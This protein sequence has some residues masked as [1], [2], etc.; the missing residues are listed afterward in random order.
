M[1]TG[2]GTFEMLDAINAKKL[3]GEKKV[4]PEQLF[5]VGEIVII[6]DSR[7]RIRSIKPDGDMRLK[8]LP[9]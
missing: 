1:D 3:L 6:K 2:K 7:F 8:L 4:I 5:Q 9:K